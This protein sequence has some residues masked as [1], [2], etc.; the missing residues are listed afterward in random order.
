[1]SLRKVLRKLFNRNCLGSRYALHSSAAGKNYLAYTS[2]EELELLLEQINLQRYT[3]NT[4]TSVTKLGKELNLVRKQGYAVDNEETELGV[5][6][7]SSPIFDYQGEVAGTLGITGLASVLTPKRIRAVSTSVKA[8]ALQ[9]SKRLGYTIDIM[10]T[11][12][13]VDMQIPEVEAGKE[14]IG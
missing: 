1:M 9:L 10:P 13:R 4:L 12:N 14:A 8:L 6:C 7:M 3:S 5:K 11:A 2:P